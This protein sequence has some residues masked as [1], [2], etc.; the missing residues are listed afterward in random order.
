MSNG[1]APVP[2]NLPQ[3]AHSSRPSRQIH[4]NVWTRQT[5]D[6]L[7]EIFHP[8]LYKQN[9]DSLFVG[10]LDQHEKEQMAAKQ[11]LT[12][13]IASASIM[14][15]ASTWGL[16]RIFH[17]EN[18]EVIR[19][20]QQYVYHLQNAE[21][22]LRKALDI[23]ARFPPVEAQESKPQMVQHTPTSTPTP[24]Q[25]AVPPPPTL[26]ASTPQQVPA[27]SQAVPPTQRVG[28]IPIV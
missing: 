18:P 21:N 15:T 23:N 27:V 8:N 10:L 28:N 2:K 22:C 6:R 11:P 19:Q 7:N 14:L 1:Y 17:S 16:V 24:S 12:P 9:I 3:S 4:C 13:D 20:Y 26:Q 25:N 5:L